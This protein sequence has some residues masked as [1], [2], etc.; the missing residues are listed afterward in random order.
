[1]K[2]TPRY[3]NKS[4]HVFLMAFVVVSLGLIQELTR[5]DAKQASSS[6]TEIAPTS[7]FAANSLAASPLGFTENKGQLKHDNLTQF[8]VKQRG[9]SCYLSA[10]GITYEWAA[11]LKEEAEAGSPNHRIHTVGML[12]E[13]AN[14]DVVIEG[15]L[16]NTD[17]QHF[18]NTSPH[19]PV[20][21]VH[22]FQEIWYRELYPHIDLK[23]YMVENHMKYDFL[24]HPGGKVSDIQL[25]YQGQD[26]LAINEE[27]G[28]SLQTS[29]G[30]LTELAPFSY[31]TVQG[32]Q[33]EIPSAYHLKDEV[34]HFS[35]AAYDSTQ[36]L[37]IDPEVI[38][39][40]YYGGERLEVSEAVT[41]DKWGNVYIVGQIEQGPSVNMAT[42]QP[43]NFGQYD[44]DSYGGGGTDAFIAKFAPNGTR[45]WASYFGGEY[46]DR[47]RGVTTDRMGNVIFCGQTVSPTGIAYKGHD[48]VLNDGQPQAVYD[49]RTMDA[50]L[51][52]MNPDGLLT[53]ST[54]Y[55]GEYHEEDRKADVGKA[56]ATDEDGNIFLTGYTTS[57]QDIA[58]NGAHD[59]SLEPG[60]PDPYNNSVRDAYLVK[61]DPEGNRLWGT[62]FG[63]DGEEIAHDVCVDYAGGPVIVGFTKSEGLGY[64]GHDHSYG[65]S[66]DAFIARF[67]PDGEL[68]WSSYYGS[69]GV[70]L[71][72]SVATD[73]YNMFLAGITTSD[74]SIAING[75]DNTINGDS[76]A[77]IAAFNLWGQRAWGTYFGGENR[78]G[79][80]YYPTQE[81]AHVDICY[82]DE[83]YGP[84]GVLYLA[85]PTESET[86]I[87]TPGAM[88]PNL[89]GNE[90]GFI[91][92]FFT[93]GDLKWSTYYGGQGYDDIH[94]VAVTT[95]PDLYV[96]G[97]TGS[98]DLGY[99]GHDV[100]K[101]DN[102]DGF[103]TKIRIYS[104]DPPHQGPGGLSDTPNPTHGDDGEDEKLSLALSPNPTRGQVRVV[105]PSAKYGP[106]QIRITDTRGNIKYVSKTL[107]GALDETLNLSQFK[108]GLYIVSLLG[109]N[110]ILTKNLQVE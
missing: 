27:G 90:D 47:G 70:D 59:T 55:G 78:E 19:E 72:K 12:W 74:N 53:W 15:R 41:T 57:A 98:K 66:A 97:K 54:Y 61:F 13:N 2:R 76:D 69:D 39:A 29:L 17:L 46:S 87:A 93:N 101:D 110:K 9:L 33:R 1:M 95:Y 45:L 109:P 108:R 18:Y 35:V 79:D 22:N 21:G 75:S 99:N 24:V 56:V 23:V 63:G 31:Q 28:L 88:I 92:R 16:S 4:H 44:T 51:V 11:Q 64:Q 40:T 89:D 6:V 37:V 30:T 10:M 106:Y 107:E 48:L 32:Q 43:Q 67:S 91:A 73:G 85:G 81:G 25:T 105:Y 36:P 7:Q 8:Y 34:I 5:W 104:E 103:L 84:L 102:W 80:H 42:P 94:S 50:F 58:T 3:F 52:K 65:G 38:W 83:G 100:T 20:L 49:D 68:H 82:S 62:Y 86:G 77:F 14:P 96:T 60:V 71:G 26:Q